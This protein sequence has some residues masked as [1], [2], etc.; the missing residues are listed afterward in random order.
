MKLLWFKGVSP[1]PWSILSINISES[2][3]NW[4]LRVQIFIRFTLSTASGNVGTC[5]FLN[6]SLLCALCA[7]LTSLT[8]HWWLLLRLSFHLLLTQ[9]CVPQFPFEF[10]S[11]LYL[12]HWQSSSSLGLCFDLSRS[13]AQVIIFSPDFPIA[14]GSPFQVPA[15]R[16]T[17]GFCASD[18]ANTLWTLLNTVFP[19]QWKPLLLSLVLTFSSRS[20]WDPQHPQPYVLQSGAKTWY[21]KC[22]FH[23]FPL[24]WCCHRVQAHLTYYLESCPSLL[25]G[26]L[27]SSL[28]L[29]QL[30]LYVPR[31][32]LTE[33]HLL[34]LFVNSTLWLPLPR[35][36]DQRFNLCN[37]KKFF[38][39]RLP[40]P[41]SSSQIDL[42]PVPHLSSFYF[43]TPHLWSCC[44]FTLKCSNLL[45]FS[46]L[47]STF[48]AELKHHIQISSEA[49]G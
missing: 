46:C 45:L 27:I 47:A 8:V 30:I 40:L 3:Y 35:S 10:F 43:L 4:P 5:C 9:V 39:A 32:T 41:P 13:N 25:A 7:P 42:S 33:I 11:Y 22:F 34:F 1:S 16:L 26:L 49:S 24:F 12:I 17:D 48:K 6:S 31:D 15:G 38:Q 44:S 21:P 37:S 18:T 36:K 20:F 14:P 28:S 2:G 23:Q 19:F 29:Y